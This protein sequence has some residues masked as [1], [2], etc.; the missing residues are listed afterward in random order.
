MKILCKICRHPQRD[1]IVA[2]YFALSSLR[3]AAGIY[4]L[5]FK[6][7]HRHI[8]NCLMQIGFDKREVDFKVELFIQGDMLRKELNARYNAPRLDKR[9]PRPQS[10]ITKEVKF[11]WS[12][13][14]WKKKQDPQNTTGKESL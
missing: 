11:T 10:I 14:A 4:G 12:R 5:S 9:R 3:A 1:K 13:R 2:T 8:Q 7:L 6:T